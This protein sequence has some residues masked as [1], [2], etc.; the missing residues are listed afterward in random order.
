MPSYPEC[1]QPGNELHFDELRIT[2][3]QRPAH[4]SAKLEKNILVI[5]ENHE[6][7]FF[8]PQCTRHAASY[9]EEAR[10]FLDCS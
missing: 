5:R 7:C 1:G 2:F 10:K 4:S 9:E 3:G 8:C 6:I